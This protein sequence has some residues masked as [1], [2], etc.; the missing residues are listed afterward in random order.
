MEIFWFV[1][2]NISDQSVIK[3]C[4]E[5]IYTNIQLLQI[6]GMMREFDN[7]LP[8]SR[9]ASRGRKD[10]IYMQS[11]NSLCLEKKQIRTID[12]F[13]RRRDR[14]VSLSAIG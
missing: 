3:D 12:S 14:T 10:R 7:R 6:N 2:G 13:R 4:A 8:G 11:W 9:R 1:T 5:L